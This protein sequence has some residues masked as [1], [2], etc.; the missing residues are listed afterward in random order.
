MTTPG[1]PRLSVILATAG[2][3][4]SIRT[5][6]R[7]LRRQ[8]IAAHLEVIILAPDI[9][10]FEL[11]PEEQGAFQSVQLISLGQV[12]PVSEANALG[13]RHATAPIVVFSED[14]AFP[15]RSW[16]EALVTRHEENWAAVG[17][18]VRN[19]NPGTAVSWADYL[20]GYGPWHDARPSGEVK[21]LPGHN[22]SYKRAAL[23]RL[24]GDLT[25]L[26]TVESVLQ[27][28]LL[29]KGERLYLDNSAR[30]SHLNFARL[31]VF[32]AVQYQNGRQ[33]AACRVRSWSLGRRILYAIGSPLIPLVRFQR[34][35]SL[36]V[37]FPPRPGRT[38][39]LNALIVGLVADGAG[40]FLGYVCGGGSSHEFLKAYEYDRV[41]FITPADRE[42]TEVR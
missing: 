42:E 19:G 32:L 25:E 41:R 33:F 31:S 23:L 2:R 35:L 22:S 39:I 5:T 11:P 26:L 21:M 6:L 3:F 12:T 38:R 1:I 37:P 13:V 36:A 10:G 17:P 29:A 28:R 16:A 27:E 24:G 14:H 18:V 15:D 8:T 30:I 9:I 4:A 40:Q 7:H 34:T 20:L